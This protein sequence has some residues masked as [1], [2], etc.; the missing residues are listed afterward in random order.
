MKSLHTISVIESACYIDASHT[1]TVR[2][3]FHKIQNVKKIIERL[4]KMLKC[5]IEHRGIN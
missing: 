2:L 4:A 5:K 1:I 3:N